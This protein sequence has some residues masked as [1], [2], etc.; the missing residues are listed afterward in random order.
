MKQTL[1]LDGTS[2]LNSNGQFHFESGY[3]S[4][5]PLVLPKRQRGVLVTHQNACV[6][7]VPDRERV[8]LP[9]VVNK[10]AQGEGYYIKRTS[11]NYLINV[12]LPIVMNRRET[13]KALRGMI[14]EIVGEITLDR[15]CLFPLA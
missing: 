5:Y 10:I 15:R 6:D 12:K 4:N 1:I 7:F 14:N 2:S 9:P 11:R 3:P 13:E 8:Y